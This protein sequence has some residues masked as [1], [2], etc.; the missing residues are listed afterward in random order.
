[1]TQELVS[2]T[3]NSK[4]GDDIPRAANRL[5]PLP[6]FSEEQNQFQEYLRL[7]KTANENNLFTI[8]EISEF[9]LTS[10]IKMAN[11]KN[12]TKSYYD[13]VL[14]NLVRLGLLEEDGNVVKIRGKCGEY[15]EGEFE[16]YVF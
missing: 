1:M 5:S 9:C 4:G 6:L 16:A 11:G 13:L 3:N 10:E 7:V 12:Y 2:L 14:K 15:L 8:N